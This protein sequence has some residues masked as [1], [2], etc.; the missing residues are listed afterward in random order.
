MPV[1]RSA[2]PPPVRNR[3]TQCLWVPTSTRAGAPPSVTRTPCAMGTHNR[4][5]PTAVH[6]ERHASHAHPRMLP[7]SPRYR[8]VPGHRGSP[9]R[10]ARFD[11][12]GRLMADEV[13]RAGQSIRRELGYPRDEV[14]DERLRRLGVGRHSS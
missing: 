8:S 13:L 11:A 7:S 14:L 2:Y 1:T 10:R 12:H 4:R 6:P 9:S 3:R 5:D